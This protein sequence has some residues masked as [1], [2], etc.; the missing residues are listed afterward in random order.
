MS[1]TPKSFTWKHESSA[2]D[3]AGTAEFKALDYQR[4]FIL[5]DFDSTNYQFVVTKPTS[6]YH[7]LS[8]AEILALDVTALENTELFEAEY[9]KETSV[10]A[11][12]VAAIQE[13]KTLH[14]TLSLLQQGDS[15]DISGLTYRETPIGT[16]VPYAGAG[17]ISPLSSRFTAFFPYSSL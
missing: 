15:T 1:L 8:E 7:E 17:A 12:A 9:W 3:F 11:T 16:V 6:A 10:L 14:D 2:E 4:G 5:E 13:L